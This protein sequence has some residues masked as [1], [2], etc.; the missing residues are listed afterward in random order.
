MNQEKLKA[1]T[2]A[3]AQARSDAMD[4]VSA[5]DDILQFL[6]FQC[7]KGNFGVNIIETH[8][9][10]KPVVI[11]R[12]PN[13]EDEILGVINLRGNIIPVVDVNRKFSGKH[14]ELSNA[15]RIVVCAYQGKFMGLLVDRIMEV[16]RISSASIEGGEIKGFSNQYV[17]GV[18]RSEQRLFL[19]LNL[20]V[21]TGSQRKK[22]KEATPALES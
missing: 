15:S 17:K 19:I 18:G 2:L 16:A 6:V 22:E 8:E 21:L 14:T 7:G 10:L 11:T 13:V 5:L 1:T 12:L 20:D 3:L 9:I 4:S